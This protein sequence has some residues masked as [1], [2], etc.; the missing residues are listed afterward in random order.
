MIKLKRLNVVKLVDSEE[1][2]KALIA[3]GFI[4]VDEE[5]Q[6]V[7]EIGVPKKQTT[8]GKKTEGGE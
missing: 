6:E 3:K 7:D 8:R 1:K 5:E 4:R 2:A